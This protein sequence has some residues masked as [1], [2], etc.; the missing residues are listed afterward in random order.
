MKRFAIILLG[1]ALSG[2]VGSLVEIDD[3]SGL[4]LEARAVVLMEEAPAGAAI[5]GSVEGYSCKNKAWSP[6][7]TREAAGDQLRLRAS[8]LG[9]NA[10]VAVTYE[11][12]GTT[13]VPNCWESVKATGTAVRLP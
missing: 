10:V 8:R 1:A 4:S 3:T 5:L 9:A 7:A 6:A 11:E 2:C 12:K 13:L